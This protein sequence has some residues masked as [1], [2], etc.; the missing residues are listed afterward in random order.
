M[1]NYWTD[2][3]YPHITNVGACKWR[4]KVLA[5]I[6]ENHDIHSVLDIGCSTGAAL[7]EIYKIKPYIELCGIDISQD[8]IDYGINKD[9]NPARLICGNLEDVLD[10]IPDKSFDLVYTG[11]VLIYMF[12]KNNNYSILKHISRIAKKFIVHIE[13]YGKNT[14]HQYNRKSNTTMFANNFGKGYGKALGWGTKFNCI[15]VKKICTR[16]HLI[17]EAK[18]FIWFNLTE[19]NLEFDILPTCP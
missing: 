11:G 10:T 7:L 9:N 19:E 3:Y 15:D 18:H 17:G 5:N 8:A 12:L 4:H 6:V 1:A 2:G 16:P 14:K 13:L